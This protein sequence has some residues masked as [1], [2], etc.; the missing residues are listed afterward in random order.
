MKLKSVRSCQ[1]VLGRE[2]PSYSR[3]H[4]HALRPKIPLSAMKDKLGFGATKRGHR[5]PLGSE[6]V[7][8]VFALTLAGPPPPATRWPRRRHC[9]FGAEDMACTW[10]SAGSGAA[11]QA[12][13][14]SA[15][16]AKLKEIVGLYVNPPDHAIALSVDEKSQRHGVTTL[17]AA[18]DVLEGKVIGH[19]MK[20]HRHQD[21]L[22]RRHQRKSKTLHLDQGAQHY[23]HRR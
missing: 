8:C 13:R 3:N 10:P 12:L 18:L 15:V 9:Q 17:F 23:H 20:R 4:R 7:E 16:A 21:P 19:C 1:L 5:A 14:R 6:V 2:I 11:V 22:P